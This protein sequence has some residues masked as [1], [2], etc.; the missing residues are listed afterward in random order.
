M[1]K[2]KNTIPFY[3][4]MII[5]MLLGLIVGLIAGNKATPLGQ[6]GSLVIQLIKAVAAPLLFLTIINAILQSDVKMRSVGRMLIIVLVNALGALVIGITLADWI[7]PGLYLTQRVV[8]QG[9]EAAA[10]AAFVPPSSK[11]DFIEML[12]SYIPKS[13]VH[14][15]FENS[16]MTLALLALLIGY[17]LKQ[18]RHSQHSQ[19]KNHFRVIE[20]L[21]AT[22]L[23]LL[24]VILSWVMIFVPLAVFG[25]VAKSVGE[26][27]LAPLKGL[28]IYLL[29]EMIGFVLH[30]GLVYQAWLFFYAKMNLREFWKNVRDP[31]VYAIGANSSLA[32]LPVTLKALDKMGVSK[33]AATLGACVGTNLNHDGILLYEAMAV[34]IVAQAYGISMSV[35]QQV[36]A[37]ASCVISAMGIAG[38][39]ES[40][41]VSLSLVLGTLGL[42]VEILP[43][44]LAVDWMIGRGRTAVNVLN[45]IT[46]SVVLDH[47]EKSKKAGPSRLPSVGSSG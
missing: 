37:A 42:P 1:R 12:Q 34:F 16:V 14:P 41:F 36:V 15:F 39:P 26:Q 11:L 32:T 7:K 40:G 17:G 23:S 8:H 18:V 5:A 29:V 3:V 33:E 25:V 44:L 6:L 43:L 27:G 35:E 4:K 20:D 2:P 45:E 22:L 31:V 24:E 28:S 19:N 47:W 38:V 21:I 9:L 13:F 10:P 30:V 46:T